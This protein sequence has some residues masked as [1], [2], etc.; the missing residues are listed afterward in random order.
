M[1]FKCLF[2]ANVPDCHPEEDH[3]KL[4]TEKYAF[5]VNFIRDQEDALE[6]AEKYREEKGIQSIILCPGFTNEEVGEIS[7]LLENVSVN[8][9]RGDGPSGRIAQEAMKEA[10]W[11]E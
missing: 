2:M 1:K 3:E 7:Q 6:V 10:G 8:V 4:E 5:Y 11:F 9:A